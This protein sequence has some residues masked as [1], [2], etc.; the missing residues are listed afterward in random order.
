MMGCGNEFVRITSLLVLTKDS[1]GKVDVRQSQS[2]LGIL[3]DIT[4]VGKC[5]I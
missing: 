1:V 2:I 5:K 4:L 3:V